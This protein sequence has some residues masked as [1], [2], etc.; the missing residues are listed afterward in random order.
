L[1]VDSVINY[2]EVKDAIK[3]KVM[4]FSSQGTS[5]YTYNSFY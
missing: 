1:D 2:D 4:E 3:E 5:I